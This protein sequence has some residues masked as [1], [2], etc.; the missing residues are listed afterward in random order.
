VHGDGPRAGVPFGTAAV[1]TRGPGFPEALALRTSVAVRQVSRTVEDLVT[2]S[3]IDVRAT[4]AAV[5]VGAEVA[6]RVGRTTVAMGA[7]V[8]VAPYQL[9]VDY[10]GRRGTGGV[11][12]TGPGAVARARLG[13]RLGV[14]EVFSELGWTFVPLD[15]P[16][17]QFDGGVGGGSL[18]AGYRLTW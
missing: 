14:A 13:Y 3:T 17:V 18:V 7:G 8:V 6:R 10:G 2:G 4:V 1:A 5:D 15:T 11:G 16:T 12:L 9:E